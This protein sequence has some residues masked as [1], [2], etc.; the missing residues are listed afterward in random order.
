M[1]DLNDPGELRGK[2]L[3]DPSGADI[4]E[5]KEIYLEQ[6]SDRPAFALV[7]SGLLGSKSTF[8]PLTG[9]SL[10]GPRIWV[11]VDKSQVRDAPKVDP[12]EEVSGEQEREIYSHYGIDR[13]GASGG[14]AATESGTGE[15][16]ARPTEAHGGEAE[17]RPT[18]AHPP[19]PPAGSGRPTGGPGGT[20]E[21]LPRLRRYVV[22]EEVEITVPVQ[23]EEVRVEPP[24]E[25]GGTQA[26][27]RDRAEH[28]EGGEAHAPDH[29]PAEHEEGRTQA[30]EPQP[31]EHE[32]RP[33]PERPER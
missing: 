25:G 33:R 2:K 21:G 16:E 19:S 20:E 7:K 26:A 28:E 8:V 1:T 18:E 29:G 23:R 32:E 22:T 13:S 12:D 24:P 4:G 3:V 15:A 14:G 10:D 9:A 11:G 17:A 5:A 27:D 6:G 31:G 30:A